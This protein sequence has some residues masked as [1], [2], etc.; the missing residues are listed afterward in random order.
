MQKT[1]RPFFKMMPMILN[2]PDERIFSPPN[3]RFFAFEL[4]FLKGT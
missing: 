1:C 3:S 2:F 4:I